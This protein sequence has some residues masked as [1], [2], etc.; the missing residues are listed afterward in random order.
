MPA[1]DQ[2]TSLQAQRRQIISGTKWR[3]QGSTAALLPNVV[4]AS[5]QFSQ[6]GVPPFIR[7]MKAQRA[8]SD[9]RANICSHH[10]DSKDALAP[11]ALGLY[12]ARGGNL[13]I[14]LVSVTSSITSNSIEILLLVVQ[15]YVIRSL[16]LKRRDKSR[17]PRICGRDSSAKAVVL[18]HL[19]AMRV[20]L[21]SNANVIPDR[22]YLEAQRTGKDLELCEEDSAF[23]SSLNNCRACIDAEADDKQ[24]WL[25]YCAAMPPNSPITSIEILAS[26]GLPPNTSADVVE[27]PQITDKP[28]IDNSPAT[29]PQTPVAAPIPSTKA[30]NQ[31]PIVTLARSSI[32]SATINALLPG[33][34]LSP[35][36]TE[37]AP[38]RDTDSA[39]AT[40]PLL[41]ANNI[42]ERSFS[43]A[44]RTPASN[45]PETVASNSS[46]TT[47]SNSLSTPN[48]N[49]PENSTSSSP[50]DPTSIPPTP[51]V[52]SSLDTPTLIGIIAGI[53]HSSTQRNKTPTSPDSW[54][55]GKVQLHGKS[56]T[57]RPPPPELL[58]IWLRELV[59]NTSC[60]LPKGISYMEFEELRA[61]CEPRDLRELCE[62]GEMRELRELS[63]STGMVEL[64][65]TY[66]LPILMGLVT[67]RRRGKRGGRY[68][69]LDKREDG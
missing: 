14:Y 50:N 55:G 69:I 68:D 24:P 16:R 62:L 4:V 9:E 51:P 31:A 6:D 61:L 33:E 59:T 39:R 67:R 46:G 7:S 10:P 2:P 58:D 5:W 19:V 48:S 11:Q 42:T 35:P 26:T 53:C 32:E 34:P 49:S 29:P 18:Y 43:T 3:A 57:S 30:P 17:D 21:L 56:L 64:E 28:V 45:S 60:A 41:A 27:I 1:Q 15:A 65:K 37:I 23:L 52:T 40:A 38:V 36:A 66:D 54:P 47:S 44:I 63:A 22:A 12:N 25:D 8:S 20:A 13:A